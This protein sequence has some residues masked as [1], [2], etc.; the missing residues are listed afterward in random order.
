MKDKLP[1]SKALGIKWY[2][3][4]DEIG[5]DVKIKERPNTKRGIL[6]L[7]SSTFDPLG[8]VSPVILKARLILQEEHRH[9][10]NWDEKISEESERDWEVW[11][12]E[13]TKLTEFRLARCTRPAW[14]QSGKYNSSP[15]Q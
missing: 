13:L 2:M 15:F 4:T 11:K 14:Y 12:K 8:I 10:L 9:Q 3:E 5:V 1:G 7:L 6:S